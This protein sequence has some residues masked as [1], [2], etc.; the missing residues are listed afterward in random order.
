MNAQHNGHHVC[1]VGGGVIGA[2]S[3]FELAEAGCRVKLVDANRFGAACSHGNCGY[4]CPS[5]ALPLAQPG[6][7][8][9]N[10]F[11]SLF[12]SNALYIKP[13]LDRDLVG[14]MWR[15]MRR[16]N[17]RDMLYAADALSPLLER[18]RDLFA[19]LIERHAIDCDFEQGGLHFV[20]AT[21]E[22][23]ESFAKTADLLGERYGIATERLDRDELVAAEPALKPESVSG[24]WT[25]PRD[26]HLRPD[27]LMAALRKL[28]RDR[29]VEIREECEIVGARREG[30]K[31]VALSTSSG[32]EIAA[33]TF[34]LAT[35]A[36]TPVLT[37][38]FDFDIKLPI[39]PGKGYS[40]TTDR[41]EHCPRVPMIFEEDHVA[42]TPWKSGFRVG[43]T[44]E[45]AGYDT[46]LSTKRLANLKRASDRYLKASP[47]QPVLERWYGWRPMTPD[48]LP[49]IGRTK[50]IDNLIIATGHSMLGLSLATAT[51]RLVRELVQ[52][53]PTHLDIS[54]FDPD[55]YS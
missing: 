18:S 43:S 24:A 4:I 28:L 27:K 15:F 5:H 48:S 53:E 46:K 3:A 12:P 10:A 35:G 17:R 52:G 42:V 55:R 14:W 51:G 33:D 40:F 37:R 7:V 22:G 50:S 41:P 39:Q 47:E 30:D 29:D 34:V 20:Y 36:I 31:V 45:F 38:T 16:C 19:E 9:Q 21:V 25:F 6:A 1:V 49:M 32:D 44:M 54:A 2:L 8:R 11:K 13:R 26:A 23:F